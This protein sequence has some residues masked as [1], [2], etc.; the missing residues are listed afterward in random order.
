[1]TKNVD[2]DVLIVGAGFAGLRALHTFREQGFRVRVL[3]AS[4]E[5]GG[6]GTTTA[7]RARAATWKASTTPTGSPRRWSSNGAGR[8]AMRPSPRS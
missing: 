7:I 1:M 2:L 8:N 5:I 6:C 3:E 4:D